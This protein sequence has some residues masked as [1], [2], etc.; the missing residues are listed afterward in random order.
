MYFRLAESD[1]NE[2][3][4]A[5]V[6]DVRA[7]A[8]TLAYANTNIFDNNSNYNKALNALNTLRENDDTDQST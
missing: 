6:D 3:V 1:V 2:V 5:D 8:D 7:E 4:D